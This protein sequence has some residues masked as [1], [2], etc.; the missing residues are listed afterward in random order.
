MGGLIGVI[1]SVLCVGGM[2]R[3][4]TDVV[5]RVAQQTHVVAVRDPRFRE[6]IAFE[7]I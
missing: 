6:S 1:A 4:L 2:L 5:L 7:N 3:L